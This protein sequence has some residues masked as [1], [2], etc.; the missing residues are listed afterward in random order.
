MGDMS[1]T[2]QRG[3]LSRTLHESH[4]ESSQMYAHTRGSGNNPNMGGGGGGGLF[5]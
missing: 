2:L 5:W 1:R 3:D 4:N